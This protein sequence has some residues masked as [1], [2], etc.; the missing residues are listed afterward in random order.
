MQICVYLQEG[1]Y[2]EAC[3]KFTTA[4]NVIGYQPGKYH[5]RK[6]F[7]PLCAVLVAMKTLLS[8]FEL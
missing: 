3:Q 2:S 1:R 5:A 8:F 7:T 4:M 6:Q